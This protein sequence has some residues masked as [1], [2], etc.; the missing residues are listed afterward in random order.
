[1][2]SPACWNRVPG[3]LVLFRM[4]LGPVLVAETGGGASRFWLLVTLTAAFL[5]DVFDGVLARRLKVVTPRL[6]VADSVADRVYFACVALS[7]WRAHPEIIYAYRHPLE[8]LLVVQTLSWGVDWLRYQR[9]ASFHAYMAKLCGLLLFGASV[10]ILGFGRAAP[11]LPLALIVYVLGT[12]EGTVMVYLLPE[13][14]HDVPSVW[15]AVRL[16]KAQERVQ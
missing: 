1:M 6:R 2:L 8:A 9:I 7:V 15:H 14:T 12:V 5:S 16:R 13:W 11:L 10:S 4:V 3:L